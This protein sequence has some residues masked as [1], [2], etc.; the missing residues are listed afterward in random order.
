MDL[1]LRNIAAYIVARVLLMNGGIKGINKKLDNGDILLSIYFHNPSKSLFESCILWLKDNGFSFISLDDIDEISKGSR[2]IGYRQALIT[3]DDG[4][5]G[6]LE[7]I[8]RT[9]NIY[10][11][12]IGIFISTETAEN[13]G[14]FWWSYINRAYKMGITKLKAENL[15]SWPNEKRIELMNELKL[16]IKIPREAMKVNDIVSI[17][18]NDLHKI[19]SHTITHPILTKC[20]DVTSK[21]EISES[22]RILENWTNKSI[23][24]FA[25]PNGSFSERDI[26]YVKEAGYVKAFTTKGEYVTKKILKEE[27]NIPRFEILENVSFAENICRMT[28]LW[29]NKGFFK[30]NSK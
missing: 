30:K 22:K 25:Y 3:V 20:N 17:S 12:P 14:G 2:E 16:K 21:Y 11:V 23:K 24:Y 19:G 27:I 26:E 15:K 29:Y 7:N 4:W 28:G 5:R 13:G 10:K 18:N 1:S 8:F 9:S 6:N